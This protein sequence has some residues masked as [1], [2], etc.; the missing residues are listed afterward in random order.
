MPLR[1]G[2]PF[3]EALVHDKETPVSKRFSA[4]LAA[5]AALSL[6]Y[7]TFG[8]LPFGS[9]AG[10]G[11]SGEEY[12]SGG[13]SQGGYNNAPGGAWPKM[14]WASS[15][16]KTR[17]GGAYEGNPYEP[18]LPVYGKDYNPFS[19][20][21]SALDGDWQY[22][23]KYAEMDPANPIQKEQMG[24]EYQPRNWVE[25]MYNPNT[26][27]VRTH[28][29]GLIN[30]L[31]QN[32]FASAGGDHNVSLDP[33]GRTMF[34]ST[35]RMSKNPKLA[36][37][38]VDSKAWT[39]LTEGGMADMMPAVSPDGNTV[40]WCSNRYGNWS[41]LM[42]EL[43][44]PSGTGPKQLTS[45]PDDDIH[46]TWSPDS[47][48]L[49][50]SR[51]NS[52]DGQWQIWVMDLERKTF[53][54]I[55]EGLFPGFNPVMKR[56]TA[57]GRPIYTIAYQRHRQRDIPWYSI[58]TL[59]LAV[60][61]NGRIEAMGS[62]REIVSSNDWAAITPAWSPTGDYIAFASVR[63]SPLSE[64]QAR[65][66]R[67]DDIW[68]VRVDGTDLTQVTDHPAPDWYPFWATED[69]N[70]VGRIYF[71][72]SRKGNPTIWSVRPLL[73]GLLN[74]LQREAERQATTAAPETG[75]PQPPEEND[76]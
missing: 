36:M 75:T 70:P 6:S 59:D 26:L 33:R 64:M 17:S 9:G 1:T 40:V 16:R 27:G 73:P 29:S 25:G 61:P 46:P 39:L 22:G 11:G 74:D 24:I 54:A 71:T 55:T 20:G 35:T 31:T 8:C 52:M 68:A 58:W 19:S 15:D 50:F 47:R 30:G 43:N 2:T 13:E 48:F 37:Q 21:S 3:T 41:L 42:R 5:A 69:G 53:T 67:A 10:S 66:Y 65:I 12:R 14:G 49:A 76:T 28:G 18:S 32:T 23:E 60:Q 7:G 57:E 72:S 38:D 44:V 62:P 63:K 4:I 34:F 45:T 51:F 56:Q